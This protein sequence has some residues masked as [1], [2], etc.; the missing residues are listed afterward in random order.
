MKIKSLKVL[1]VGAGRIAGTYELDKFRKNLVR[2]L[3][4]LK[5]IKISMLKVL[6]TLKLKKA[7]NSQKNSKFN[8][9]SKL[10][11]L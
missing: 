4:L 5:K 3:E 7:F 9:F 8:S 11:K 10:K 1:I 6:L 2:I